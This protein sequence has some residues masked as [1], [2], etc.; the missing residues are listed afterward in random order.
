MDKKMK[1]AMKNAEKIQE[2][3]KKAEDCA[4]IEFWERSLKQLKENRKTFLNNV[5][6]T[7]FLIDCYTTKINKLKEELGR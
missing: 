5:A 7:N 2:F 6:E 1:E 3:N 4:N